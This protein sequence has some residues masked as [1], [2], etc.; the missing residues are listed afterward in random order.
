VRVNLRIC[1]ALVFLMDVNLHVMTFKVV[2]VIGQ[3]VS[4]AL[5]FRNRCP[6][7]G[8]KIRVFDPK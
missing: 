6:V 8:L 3:E 5:I 7:R 1:S 4:F 2:V